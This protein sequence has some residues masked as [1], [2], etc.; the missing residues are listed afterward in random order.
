MF[1]EKNQSINHFAVTLITG[2]TGKVKSQ[3]IRH[4]L[5]FKQKW[6]HKPENYTRI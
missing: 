3:E 2:K 4:G 5:L 1:T 6:R